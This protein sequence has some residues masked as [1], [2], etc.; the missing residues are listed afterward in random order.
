MTTL[1]LSS[2]FRIP[3][4]MSKYEILSRASCFVLSSSKV[5]QRNVALSSQRSLESSPSRSPDVRPLL[6]TTQ[7]VIAPQNYRNYYPD[8][9][10][11]YVT[12]EHVKCYAEQ[13]SATGE[14]LQSWELGK[15]LHHPSLDL[16]VLPFKD[17]DVALPGYEIS[18]IQDRGVSVTCVG[19][20]L[21]D[22]SGDACGEVQDP[23]DD[24][25]I[26]IPTNV[27][28]SLA[29][30][31]PRQQNFATTEAVLEPGMCGG[32]MINGSGEVVGMVEGIVPPGASVDDELE[33]MAAYVTSAGLLAVTRM[34][35]STERG[36]SQAAV[37]KKSTGVRVL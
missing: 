15:P 5:G 21:R 11:S 19:H 35:E 20:V 6:L 32:P 23:E 30:Q 25:R 33:G 34:W 1:S 36:D 18:E 37:K 22:D 13:R 12:D 29:L 8:D 9:W 14:V 27:T 2:Y 4:Q 28:G 26:A 7:H 16:S 3:S 24:T 17:D 31:T 10:I